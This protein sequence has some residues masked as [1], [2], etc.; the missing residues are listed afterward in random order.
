MNQ[1][2]LKHLFYG[3]VIVFWLLQ[4][5]TISAQRP[6]TSK[7]SDRHDLVSNIKKV[8][9]DHRNINYINHQ[10]SIS[11]EANNKKDLKIHREKLALE[12]KIL[13]EDLIHAK[14]Q[15]TS[16]MKNKAERIRLLE[17]ELKASNE[18]YASIRNKL[19]KDLAKKNDFA[20]KKDAE[21]LLKAVQERNEAST[22]LSME[23]SDMLE[24]VNAIDEAWRKVRQNKN[25]TPAKIE[26]ISP[27]S[28]LT[29]K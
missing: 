13:K 29:N 14:D 1:L 6:A 8:Q 7:H 15:V 4:A 16:Y 26:K 23:K 24:T 12:K 18:R 27:G 5:G 20:L 17:E 10:I 22:Q 28:N 19:K 3:S 11:K 2:Y 21:D 9:A 25:V